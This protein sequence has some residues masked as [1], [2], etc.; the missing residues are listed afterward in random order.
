MIVATDYNL[1]QISLFIVSS[2]PISHLTGIKAIRS[3]TVP[4][5]QFLMSLLAFDYNKKIRSEKQTSSD[6]KRKS[7]IHWANDYNWDDYIVCHLSIMEHVYEA[8]SLVPS[9]R[10]QMT[11]Y[12][13]NYNSKRMPS[14]PFKECTFEVLLK[15]PLLHSSV[16]HLWSLLRLLTY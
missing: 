9:R 7:K 5:N 2:K 15:E 4:H 8:A 14:F 12:Y 10:K 13:Y 11:G 16:G 6:H 3:N 1:K